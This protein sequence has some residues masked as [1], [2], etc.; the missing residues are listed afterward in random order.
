MYMIFFSFCRYIWGGGGP[1]PPPQYQKAGYATGLCC[2]RVFACVCTNL[3]ACV[4]I[5]L[6]VVC[7]CVCVFLCTWQKHHII[8]VALETSYLKKR[9]VFDVEHNCNICDLTIVWKNACQSKTTQPNRD[10]L[11]SFYSEKVTLSNGIS[12]FCQ[13]WATLAVRFWWVH[14]VLPE[15]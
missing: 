2:V 4:C 12:K 14:P 1:P 5:Y 11:V 15:N 8:R 6:C 7:V 9:Y 10:I 3:C 13:I